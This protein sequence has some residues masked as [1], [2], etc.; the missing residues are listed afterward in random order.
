MKENG[1]TLYSTLVLAD[2][3]ARKPRRNSKK[4]KKATDNYLA[5]APRRPGAPKGNRNALRHGKRSAAW[6][7][8][9]RALRTQLR[10]LRELL[11]CARDLCAER[12]L[13]ALLQ[14][15]VVATSVRLVRGPP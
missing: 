1:T 13:E 2:A 10:E 14:E 12:E 11:G 6:I 9:R 4:A 15:A 8:R 7:A 3:A 5:R